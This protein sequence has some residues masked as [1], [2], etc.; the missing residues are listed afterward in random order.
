MTQTATGARHGPYSSFQV[1]TL[2]ALRMLIG[3]HFCYEGIAKLLN[4]YWTSAGYLAGSQWFLKDELIDLAAN[5]TAVTVVDVLNEWG[6][7]AIGLGLLLGALARPAA[8]AGVV[9]LSLYWIV[10]PPFAGVTYPMPAEGSYVLVNK[11][12]VE[13][14]ALLVVV[15]FPTSDVYGLDRFLARTRTAKPA[16]HEAAAA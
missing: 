11:V 2:V 13:L 16:A 12:L 8:I 5:A 4:P 9:L 3:W 6:L 14:V 15:A 7:V 10:A 1:T